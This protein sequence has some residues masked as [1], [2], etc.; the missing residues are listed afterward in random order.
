MVAKKVS[1]LCRCI[2]RH[3]FFI[4]I[5]FVVFDEAMVTFYQM[6]TE[7]EQSVG[8]KLSKLSYLI[9]SHWQRQIWLN[10]S[11]I[12]IEVNTVLLPNQ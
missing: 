3:L 1:D 4:T 10:S 5:L 11:S 12:L 7:A 8:G 9:Y 2:C 6:I